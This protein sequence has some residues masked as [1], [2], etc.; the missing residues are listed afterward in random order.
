M[1]CRGDLQA[2][3]TKSCREARPESVLSNWR[4][5]YAFTAD[6]SF[7]V[8]SSRRHFSNSFAS[9]GQPS[10][11]TVSMPFASNAPTFWSGL[12]YDQ[13]T[14]RF[15]VQ[16]THGM[17]TFSSSSSIGAG[18][19]AVTAAAISRPIRKASAFERPGSSTNSESVS[20]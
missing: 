19:A 11:R 9:A 8:N 3:N 7:V 12:S 10:R 16:S 2:A 14:Y 18:F 13:P 6:R 5:A 17:Y 4:S 15:L 1:W 20:P